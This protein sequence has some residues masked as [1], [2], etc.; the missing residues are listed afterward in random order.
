[1][2]DHKVLPR[3]GMILGEALLEVARSL[4]PEANPV[5]AKSPRRVPRSAETPVTKVAYY[6]D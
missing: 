5:V 2:K 4:A 3:D 6:F 1:M